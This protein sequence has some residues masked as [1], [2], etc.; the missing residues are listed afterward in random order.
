[1]GQ[2]RGKTHNF[3]VGKPALHR[4]QRAVNVKEKK[5]KLRFINTLN[6]HSLNGNIKKVKR[7][8]TL[9]EDRPSM[10]NRI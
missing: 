3:R 1:M 4:M 7:Q 10:F 6:F 2:E 9:G 5:D 8:A